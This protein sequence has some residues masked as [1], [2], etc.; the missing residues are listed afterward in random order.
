MV[1]N[2]A[3]T[4]TGNVFGKVVEHRRGATEVQERNAPRS[5]IL[6]EIK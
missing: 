3:R 5:L 6:V 1:W 2:E 4:L